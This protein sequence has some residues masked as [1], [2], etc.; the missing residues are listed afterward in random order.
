MDIADPVTR[1]VPDRA[2]GGQS[3]NSSSGLDGPGLRE[4]LAALPRKVLV[5]LSP[6]EVACFLE[7]APGIR[8]GESNSRRGR[9]IVQLCRSKKKRPSRAQQVVNTS[10]A[11][12]SS[13]P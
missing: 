7:A 11:A 5:A 8:T 2:A 12:L 3:P 1:Q 10:G 6:D 13:A 4:P 9:A